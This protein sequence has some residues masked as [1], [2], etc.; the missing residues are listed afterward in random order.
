MARKKSFSEIPICFL[1]NIKNKTKAPR[2]AA[3]T[4]IFMCRPSYIE[5]I[6]SNSITTIAAVMTAAI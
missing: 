3:K 6:T 5:F 4:M 2:L 1:V